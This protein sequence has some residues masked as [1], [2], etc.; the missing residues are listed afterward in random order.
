MAQG[1]S[2][3]IKSLQ[4]AFLSPDEIRRMSAVKVITADT[5][6]DD[7]YPIEMGLMDLHLGVIEPNLRCRTC[8]GRVN[9]CP[10]T[11]RYHR[12]RHAG[13]PRRLL[14]GDQAPAPV[15]LPACGRMLPD[16]PTGAA[17]MSG[18][19]DGTA[20]CPR[21]QPGKSASARTATRSSSAS[22]CD[23]PTTFREN[24]HK[25]TPKEVRARLERIPNDDVRALGLNPDFGRPEWMAYRAARPAGA[26]APVYHARQRRAAARM[27]SPTS[28]STCSGSTSACART[29]TWAP[30]SSSSRTS[31]SSCSTTSPPTSTTRRAASRRR[32]TAPAARSRRSP[33]ASRARTD[34][35][36]PTCRASG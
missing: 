29:A 22:C 11:L 24:G 30:R 35:S 9:E 1:L 3:W 28:S 27:T 12:A 17:E 32:A 4:F 13:D 23:K 15:H 20:P 2:K 21:E 8:G 6:D 18:D 16:A 26:G 14:Q 36:V 34:A 19:D 5:Y 31:G 7:G 33:S 10:G 25:I